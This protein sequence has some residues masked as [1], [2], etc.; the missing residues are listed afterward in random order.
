[1]F[2]LSRLYA[3]ALSISLPE[4]YSG[5]I[6]TPRLMGM[7]RAR[8]DG[9]YRQAH[10]LATVHSIMEYPRIFG[11]VRNIGTSP[12]PILRLYHLAVYSL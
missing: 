7:G 1:M 10:V 8:R 4:I 5:E 11:G 9:D 6:S 12:A 3:V 2:D